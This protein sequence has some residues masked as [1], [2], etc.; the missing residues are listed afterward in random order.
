[1]EHVVSR[2]ANWLHA[3]VHDEKCTPNSVSDI[4]GSWRA[5]VHTPYA[6]A[7]RW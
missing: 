3:R 5:N 1:M 2:H 4:I 6:I 7:T